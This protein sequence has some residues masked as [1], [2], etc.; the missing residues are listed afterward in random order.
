MTFQKPFRSCNFYAGPGILPESVLEEAQRDLLNFKNTGMS[1]MEISHR[2]PE[3]DEVI[4]QAEKDLRTLLNIP[5]NYKVI[6]MQGGGT[7]QFAAIPLNLLGSGI[8]DYI[9][10]G[11]WSQ[12]HT[13]RQKNMEELILLPVQNLLDLLKFQQK[14]NGN[15]LLALLICTIAQTKPSMEWNII[16]KIH[17]KMFLLFATCLQIFCQDLLTLVNLG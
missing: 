3:F 12:K 2:S 17:Q 5:I 7:A 10:T 11:A 16:L 14:A 9:I 1:I 6:F 13:L 8:G 4:L 15:T